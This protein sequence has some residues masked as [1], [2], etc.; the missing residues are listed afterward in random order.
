M[1]TVQLE[2]EQLEKNF[3]EDKLKKINQQIYNIKNKKDIIVWGAG[4]HS[5]YLFRYTNILKYKIKVVD[6]NKTGNYFGCEITSP[7]DIKWG[8]VTAVIISGHKSIEKIICEL[9]EKY[10]YQGEI[11]YFYE[12]EEIWNFWELNKNKNSCFWGDFDSFA[13]A[14]KF[15][16][17]WNESET[18]EQELK[19]LQRVLQEP[20]D[21]YWE[22]MV[23]KNLQRIYMENHQ[24]Y[25]YVI[26]FGGGFG[27]EYLNNRKLLSCMKGIK[28]IVVDQKEHVA[29]GKKYLETEELKF[30]ESLAEA[31]KLTEGK[32]SLFILGSV[33]Q[34]IE[35]W[36][37]FLEDI[38]KMNVPYLLINRQHMAKRERV[39]IQNMG[40]Y[41]SSSVFRI[42]KKQDILDVVLDK[43]EM[44]DQKEYPERSVIFS[45]LFVEEKCWLF[46]RIQKK[47]PVNELRR[48]YDKYQEEYERK[49]LQILRSGWYVLGNEVTL[50]EKEFAAWCQRNECVGVASGLDAL[51]LAFRVIGIESGDEV[52]IAGNAYIACVIGITAN[53]G[54]PV[55]V[56]PD[57]YYELDVDQI[58]RHI[59]PR[60]KA[61]LAVHLYGQ[62]CRMDKIMEIAHRH[63]LYVVEDCAQ[64]HGAKYQ[65]KRAGSY[66]D[67]SCFSFY[68]SKNLGGFGDGGAVV[69]NKSEFADRMRVLRNYGKITKYQNTEA[70]MNSRLDEFQAGLL[71]IKLQHIEDINEERKKIAE[72]Y[73][74][75][76]KND[77]I[78]LPQQY[79]ES[80]AVWHLFVIRCELRQKLAEYLAQTEIGFDYHY[81]IPPHLSEAYVNLGIRRG[82]LPL[83]EKYAD[84]V[85]SIPIFNGMLQSEMDYVIEMINAF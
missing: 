62:M 46:R 72:Y 83:T 74:S 25:L 28:W 36:K 7:E 10:H 50:F 8:E 71:R 65:G 55:F 2:K 49:A 27:Q 29:Y 21:W 69:T 3:Y 64:A 80:E 24:E 11:V 41:N 68:P 70:G 35:E 73:L 5:D 37:G 4:K 60:T 22:Q 26:D 17:V 67:V 15:A 32:C 20:Q 33:L 78:K 58:E 75:R 53:G 23:R 51:K 56:E 6:N 48:G 16:D 44:F 43:Y 30:T 34:Y 9:K 81:P 84:E 40:A 42:F 1:Y 54:L 47:V 63:G 61:I 59:T 39:C 13:D 57:E 14:C 18:F 12:Q 38:L 77:K 79:A 45:D 85:L 76:I 66:G 19:V 52:L 31:V 82:D